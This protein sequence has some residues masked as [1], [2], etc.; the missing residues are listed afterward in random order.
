M[1]VRTALWSHK[2]NENV[3]GDCLK[4][5]YDVPAVWGPSADCAR[6][7]VKLQCKLRR[8]RSGTIIRSKVKVK[9]QVKSF[10][11]SHRF[12][13][14]LLE[15][16]SLPL[17]WHMFNIS[18]ICNFRPQLQISGGGVIRPP[19]P[20]FLSP[21][22]P[23]GYGRQPSA[24]FLGGRRWQGSSRQPGKRMSDKKIHGAKKQPQ[25][26]AAVSRTNASLVPVGIV[27]GRGQVVAI[28][29][30]HCSTVAVCSS[31]SPITQTCIVVRCSTHVW[32][33]ED[34]SCRRLVATTC[35]Q[36]SGRYGSARLFKT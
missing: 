25:G 24:A 32:T 17:L 7:E 35:W 4:R 31:K 22:W 11:T 18:A 19:D 21:C 9:Y 23:E 33:L 26:A 13:H 20:V 8:R 2:P 16:W 34:R 6:L 5:L 27:R 29:L 3:F 30:G 28:L 15:W 14:H 36:S 10:N 1:G 12:S